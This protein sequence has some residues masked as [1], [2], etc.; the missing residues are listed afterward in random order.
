[1]ISNKVGMTEQEE[2]IACSKSDGTAI[3]CSRIYDMFQTC[4]IELSQSFQSLE[5]GEYFENG[6]MIFS[7][8]ELKGT[9][10]QYIVHPIL[11]DAMI[12]AVLYSKISKISSSSGSLTVRKGVKEI[13][14]FRKPSNTTKYFLTF[15]VSSQH[16]T[17]SLP[18]WAGGRK[19]ERLH[20]C[21]NRR[22]VER[23]STKKSP[24]L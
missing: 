21:N 5:K 15:Y 2:F 20:V 17:E 6:D 1:V 13:V 19:N 22:K 12:Q 8:S 7:V 16:K 11:L 14:L 23:S 3:N 10:E 18:K 24:N 9:D 4:G